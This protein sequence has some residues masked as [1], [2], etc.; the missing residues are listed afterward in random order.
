MVYEYVCMYVYTCELAL[1]GLRASL[2][3]INTRYMNMYVR[4]CTYIHSATPEDIIIL[5]S[6]SYNFMLT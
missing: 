1:I 6:T 3:W 2:A 5:D 4:M